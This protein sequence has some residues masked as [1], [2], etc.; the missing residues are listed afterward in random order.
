MLGTHR[1]P[2]T[3]G[4]RRR[5]V[6]SFLDRI[7][8]FTFQEK[9]HQH[10]VQF[11]HK[12]YAKA[13]ENHIG[14]AFYAQHEGNGRSHDQCRHG[15]AIQKLEQVE[16]HCPE[17]ATHR[18]ASLPREESHAQL[19]TD[20]LLLHLLRSANR[21]EPIDEEH[22][23]VGECRAACTKLLHVQT[24]APTELRLYAFLRR[25]GHIPIS[26]SLDTRSA[27]VAAFKR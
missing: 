17:E 1:P 2:C 3:V 23:K 11:D 12:E 10:V 21:D 6:K 5:S 7:L 19:G 16:I 15:P 13:I 8:L 18:V 22:G 9:D 26:H 4:A 20:R 27:C 24:V 14:R 25:E